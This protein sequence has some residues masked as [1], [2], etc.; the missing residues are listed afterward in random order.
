M[1]DTFESCGVIVGRERLDLARII[2]I[3]GRS[4]RGT[5]TFEA[6]I[7]WIR[8]VEPVLRAEHGGQEIQKFSSYCDVG[9]YMTS[10]DGAIEDAI[11]ACQRFT[12]STASSLALIIDVEVTETPVLAPSGEP[13]RALFG[14]R[15]YDAIPKDWMYRRPEQIEACLA[16]QKDQ[17][18]PWPAAGFPFLKEKSI[19]HERIWSSANTPETNAGQVQAFRDRWTPTLLPVPTASV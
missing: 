2:D 7:L 17:D 1:R 12:V 9:R 14:R 8:T 10:I 11:K 3:D 19:A 15:R 5:V 16:A 4:F 6:D 13:E 18:K